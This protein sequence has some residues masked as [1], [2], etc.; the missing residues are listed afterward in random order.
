MGR[1]AFPP[2]PTMIFQSASIF[3][4]RFGNGRHQSL[5][6]ATSCQKAALLIKAGSD[7]TEAVQSN[8]PCGMGVLVFTEQI[9]GRSLPLSLASEKRGDRG[10]ENDDGTSY[11]YLNVL[12]GVSTQKT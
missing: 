4:C 3:N 11:C 7:E 9:T 10:V 12:C 6:S 1:S 5:A 2:A 8:S